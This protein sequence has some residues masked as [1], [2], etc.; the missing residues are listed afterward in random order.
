MRIRK[1]RNVV[2]SVHT[3]VKN[4]SNIFVGENTL[5]NGGMIYA[6]KESKVVIGN[7]CLI[8]YNVVIRTYSHN[9]IKRDELIINQGNF[10]KDILIGDDVWIGYGAQIFPG[11]RIG[12][13][14]VVA[15]GAIVTKNVEDYSVVAGIPAKI[16]K[17]RE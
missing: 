10:Q 7:N 14:A 6:G 8:S 17:R 9:Y 11:V 15:A 12:N 4:S 3:K 5:I 16:I 2:I 1:G 13:G